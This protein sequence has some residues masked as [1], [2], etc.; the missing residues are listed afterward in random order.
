MPWRLAPDC[1]VNFRFTV[2]R[3]SRGKRRAAL[4]F[5]SSQGSAVPASANDWIMGPRY[6]YHMPRYAMTTT[7]HFDGLDVC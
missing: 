3:I 5:L 7:N 1:I 6:T 2:G 4:L